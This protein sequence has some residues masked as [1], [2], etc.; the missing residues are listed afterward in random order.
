MGNRII[1]FDDIYLNNIYEVRGCGG[2]VTQLLPLSSGYASY[3]LKME[4]ASSSEISV[5][6]CQTTQRHI[7]EYTILYSYCRENVKSLSK[8][9]VSTTLGLLVYGRQN[10]EGSEL[11]QYMIVLYIVT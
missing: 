3:I 2:R 5:N 8:K 9:F 10:A 1:E 11:P 7:P 6:I 4:T